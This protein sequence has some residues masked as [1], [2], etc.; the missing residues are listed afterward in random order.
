MSVPH[1][2]SKIAANSAG[3]AS[4]NLPSILAGISSSPADIKHPTYL[5]LFHDIAWS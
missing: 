3:I 1:S 5:S 2:S 4:D